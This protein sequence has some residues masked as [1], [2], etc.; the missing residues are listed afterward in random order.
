MR[1]AKKDLELLPEILDDGLLASALEELDPVVEPR[2]GGGVGCETDRLWAEEQG[3]LLRGNLELDVALALHARQREAEAVNAAKEC[4]LG[5]EVQA[6]T[7]DMLL[8][9][10]QG[11]DA[12]TAINY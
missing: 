6:D 9:Q 8:H 4:R 12:A 11:A 10:R 5:L 3:P 2:R 1:L 7:L